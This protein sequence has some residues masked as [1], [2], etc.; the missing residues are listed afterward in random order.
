MTYNYN[1]DHNLGML[2]YTKPIINTGLHEHTDPIFND[3]IL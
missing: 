2:I 3:D 1:N